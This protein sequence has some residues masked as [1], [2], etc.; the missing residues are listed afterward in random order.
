MPHIP[1][2]TEPQQA[3]R[4]RLLLAY[5]LPALLL[6]AL[7]VWPLVAGTRTL[8]LRDVLN[9]HF[10][11]KWYQAQ[12]MQE[13]RLPLVDPHRGGGQ[14]HTGN[15]NTVPLYPDNLLYLV[16][17]PLWAL[18]AHFWLHLLITPASGYLLGRGWGLRRE[19]AWAVGV[20]FTASGYY[21]SHF[22]LYN[23]VAPVTLAPA[24]IGAALR[25]GEA[26][27]R[28]R[29]F[30]ALTVL[31][32]LMILGGDPI[33]AALASV[34]A[35]SAVAVRHGRR[36]PWG[37]AAGAFAI[38]SLIAA[39]QWIEFLRIL[40]LS[41][42][43]YWGYDPEAALV[44][45]LH[46]LGLLE[47]L[48]VFAYGRPD[49]S[50][51]GR[52][53]YN[54]HLPLLFSLFPGVL[55]LALAAIARRGRATGWAWVLVVAGAGGALGQHN[56]LMRWLLLLPGAGLFRMP[57]KLWLAAA[58]GLSLLAG[59]GA[60]TLFEERGRLRL[61][62]ALLVLV[63]GYLLAW[64]FFTLAPEPIEGSLRRLIVRR[65]PAEFVAGERVRW[66][67]TC[68]LTLGVLVALLAALR[69]GRRRPAASLPWLLGIHAASQL[70]L[71]RPLLASDETAPYR[72][73][74]ALA[75]AVPSGS[76]VVFGEDNELF[77]AMRYDLSAY[78]DFR[79][80]WQ[81]RTLYDALH[82]WSGVQQGLA[83]DFD[84]SPEGLNSFLTQITFQTMM[85][86]TDT[87][88]LRLLRAAGVDTL[89]LSR[90]LDAEAA[91]AVPVREVARGELRAGTVRVYRLLDTA[92]KALL[93]G[94][95]IGFDSLNEALER[96]LSESFDPHRQAIL[97]GALQPRAGPPGTVELLQE[98]DEALRLEV[99][100]P[101]GGALVVQR[102][103]LP[104]Y[105]ATIDGRPARL[106]AANLH[107]LGLLVE[108]GRHE[109]RIWVDR[110]PLALGAALTL[111]GCLALA[112][113]WRRLS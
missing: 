32:A 91:A 37:A 71:L 12:A 52:V 44:A 51:W 50:Y 74:P 42:R 15:P 113:G 53:F 18:N 2:D 64:A 1:G 92:P 16:A 109:V 76:R 65:F 63:L 13:G 83:Y 4:R 14:A 10:G 66:A 87:E 30:V 75:A 95:V 7:A 41:Y 28:R 59:L 68:L 39:P 3:T 58:V 43:G 9:T 8:Y 90:D 25:L 94:E 11:M 73:R 61:R 101:A 24:T 45:S 85:E 62:Q 86:R 67:G 6:S 81:E 57:L 108:P 77:G 17:D 26:T 89:L 79:L 33:T 112:W 20:C 102:T 40:G 54:G 93:A 82:P 97:A 105:R 60:A 84:I 88:R 27:A 23:L 22:N 98:D 110:R 31:W 21:L 70:F 49:L 38:G 29:W 80:L 107:R 47:L 55:A 103:F 106:A 36:Y 99:D 56:P 96:L 69:V 46:P 19:A 78:P 111:L 100:S 72:H 48:L 34:L 104:I 35:A 5:A